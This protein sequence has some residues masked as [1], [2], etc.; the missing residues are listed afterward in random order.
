MYRRASARSLPFRSQKPRVALDTSRIMGTNTP[1]TRSA[2]SCILGLDRVACLASLR[3]LSINRYLPVRRVFTR[4]PPDTSI[5][6]AY[7][8]SPSL[9][10]TG[11]GSPVRSDSST[12]PDPLS[13]RPSTGIVSPALTTTIAPGS[14]FSTPT[15]FVEPSSSR[16]RALRGIFRD[17]SSSISSAFLR[18]LD[19]IV[20]P[21]TTKNVINMTA[22]I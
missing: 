5:V 11:S 18:S 9:L 16:I 19:S 12:S 8:R 2:S 7:T 3:I 1:V 15:I 20:L 14:R 6:P 22:S 17:P 21:R 10:L 13:T 4:I